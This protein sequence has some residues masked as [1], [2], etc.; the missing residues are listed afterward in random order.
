MY[1]CM[2]R[3]TCIHITFFIDTSTYQHE[4]TEEELAN[5]NMYLT[6]TI[7]ARIKSHEF[8]YSQEKKIINVFFFKVKEE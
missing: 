6:L 1:V 3:L 4:D 2:L 8:L 5:T 7:V